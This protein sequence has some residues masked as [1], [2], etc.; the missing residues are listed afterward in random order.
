MNTNKLLIAGIAFFAI[1]GSFAVYGITHNDFPPAQNTTVNEDRSFSDELQGNEPIIKVNKA[2]IKTKLNDRQLQLDAYFD[3]AKRLK[4][5]LGAELVIPAF[6]QT[7]LTAEGEPINE[8]NDELA[9]Y[10][11]AKLNQ[12]LEATD[13]QCYINGQFMRSLDTYDMDEEN[14]SDFV[15]QVNQ[16][17]GL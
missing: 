3:K 16:F 6:K 4:G 12:C 7:G 10:V 17:L 8:P 5:E 13:N 9:V 11:V 14:I 15:S 1:I 2:K